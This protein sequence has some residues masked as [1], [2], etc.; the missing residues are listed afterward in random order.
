MT[1]D[2]MQEDLAVALNNARLLG[3]KEIQDGR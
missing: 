3:R 2:R 1:M